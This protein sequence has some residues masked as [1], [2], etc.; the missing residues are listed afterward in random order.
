MANYYHE[1]R[2]HVRQLTKMSDDKRRRAERR[3]ELAEVEASAADV[4][5]TPSSIEK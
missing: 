2:A 3:A 4:N 1:A 5:V